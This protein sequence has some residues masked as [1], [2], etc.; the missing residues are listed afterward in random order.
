MRVG[1]DSVI[2]LKRLLLTEKK[3]PLHT[4][5]ALTSSPSEERRK[6]QNTQRYGLL[7]ILRAFIIIGL[8]RNLTTH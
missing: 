5:R 3:A 6:A 8:K 2:Y 7:S 4:N 1:L